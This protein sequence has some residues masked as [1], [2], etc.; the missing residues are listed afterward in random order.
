MK[1]LLSIFFIALGLFVSIKS[2][3]MLKFFGYSE[4]A[5]T[6]FRIW[7]GSRMFYKLIGIAIVFGTVMFIT[8]WAQDI[9]S[10]L[11]FFG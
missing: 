11:F 8:D 2:E 1:Y 7:G 9:L 6:K 4:W 3:W 5:E 10:Q